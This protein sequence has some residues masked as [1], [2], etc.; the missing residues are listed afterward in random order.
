M[1]IDASA[2]LSAYFPDE[3]LPQA[4]ELV[5]RHLLGGVQLRAPCLLLYEVTNVVWQGERRKRIASAQGDRILQSIVGLSLEL[6]DTTAMDALALARKY[7]CSAYDA[8][9]LALAAQLEEQLIT[10]DARLYKA[11]SHDFRWIGWIQ[12]YQ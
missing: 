9:Y 6:Y 5:R 11:V 7:N 4:Q 8:A 12:D 3:A 2:L 1:I 10:G